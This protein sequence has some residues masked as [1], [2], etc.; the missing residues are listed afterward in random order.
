MKAV[1]TLLDIV[2]EPIDLALL[3]A[4]IRP[5]DGGIVTFF[6]RVRGS[7]EDARTVTGLCY[8]AYEP[9]ARAEFASIAREA[10]ERFGDVGIAIVHRIGA[11]S[12]GDISVGILAAAAHRA[13]AFDACRFAIEAVKRRAPIWKKERYAD[14]TAEWKENSP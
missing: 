10:R 13:A 4:A 5:G 6:G 3:E 8:E 7:A 2:E 1:S 12:P 9:M 14:G 11:L